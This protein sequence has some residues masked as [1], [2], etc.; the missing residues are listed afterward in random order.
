M[1]PFFDLT[2]VVKFK[3]MEKQT[4]IIYLVFYHYLEEAA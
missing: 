2:L 1:D 4:I 3:I